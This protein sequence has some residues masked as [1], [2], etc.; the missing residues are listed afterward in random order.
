MSTFTANSGSMRQRSAPK[1]F[2]PL[3]PCSVY[4]PLRHMSHSPTAQAGQGTGSRLAHDADDVIAGLEAA[5]RRRLAHAAERL[6]A[7]DQP[8]RARA[9]PRRIA[10]DDLAIGAADAERERIDQD[11]AFGRRRLRQPRCSSTE[12]GFVGWTVIA[13]IA[14]ALVMSAARQG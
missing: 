7:E 10:G 2:S 11:R 12:F 1:P 4:W 13:R 9:A 3:M 6:V 14:N 5:I 8:L